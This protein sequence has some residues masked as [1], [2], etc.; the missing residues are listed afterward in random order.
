MSP[1]RSTSLAFA[2]VALAATL[3]GC[4]REP[5]VVDLSVAETYQRLVASKLPD[6]VSNRQ[7]GIL[8]YVTPNGMPK[9]KVVWRVASSGHDMVH[10]T[11]TLTPVSES[12]TKVDLAIS[13]GPDGAEA[14]SGKQFYRRP[15]FN[16]PLRPA[17]EEQIAAL[18]E[19]RPYDASRVP[20][21]TDSVCNVQRARLE[22]SGRP[23]RVHGSDM[24][25]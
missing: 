18:L 22:E 11:A 2:T 25:G 4:G 8:I 5:G 9:Q 19:S 17:V 21:G 15:A 14:Y 24:G 6:L 10:F 13:S 3:T 12:R 16:Q 1:F 20:R 7:C 23:F